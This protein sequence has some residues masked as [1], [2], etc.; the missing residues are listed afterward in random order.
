M[1]NTRSEERI[2]QFG[3][4]LKEFRK[5]S[6]LSIRALAAIADIDYSQIHRIEKGQVNPTLT[7]IYVLADA[8]GITPCKFFKCE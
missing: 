4:K 3:E 1:N 5:A 6:K 8:L 7:T 2:K